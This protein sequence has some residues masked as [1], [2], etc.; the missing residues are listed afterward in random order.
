MFASHLCLSS[1]VVMF[2]PLSSGY[3][4][5][6]SRFME[7]CQGLTSMSKRNFYPLFM[8]AWQVSFKETTI[9]KAFQA[10]GLL[11]FNPEVIPKM[12]NI[13]DTIEA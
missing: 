1:D 6:V 5:G 10:T 3:S 12:F 7:R 2:R 11:P 13:Q 9:F 4:H 8:A